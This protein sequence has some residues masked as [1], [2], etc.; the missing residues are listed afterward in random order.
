MDSSK[1]IT[2][3]MIAVAVITLAALAISTG[4]ESRQSVPPDNSVLPGLEENLVSLERITEH[5]LNNVRSVI[6]SRSNGQ[7]IT[8]IRDA[9]GESGFGLLDTAPADLTP[10]SAILFANASLLNQ[11]DSADT[12]IV[13]GVA[14]ERVMGKLKYTTFDGLVLECIVF[15]AADDVWLRMVAAHSPKLADRFAD[16][17]ET[18]LL[19]ADEIQQ[20]ARRLNGRVYRAH[21]RFR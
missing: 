11:L 12:F 3:I 10:F 5:P 7:E 14:P 16:S 2:S 17:A 9:P 6:I 15:S 13:T 20:T 21:D 1:R 8:V 19:S 18:G 4:W